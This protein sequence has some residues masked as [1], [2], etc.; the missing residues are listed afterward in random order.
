MRKSCTSLIVGTIMETVDR[1][2]VLADS[3][4]DFRGR[5]GTQTKYLQLKNALESAWQHKKKIYG[6]SW[7]I[8]RAFDSVSRH[9]IRAH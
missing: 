1:N 3:Q 8:A 9:L 5:R 2:G 6:S 7:D 4:H